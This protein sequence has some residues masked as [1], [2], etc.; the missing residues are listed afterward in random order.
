MEPITPAR[1]YLGVFVALLILTLATFAVSFVNLGPFNAVVAL[2]IAS[3]K[4]IL[5]VLF[6]MHARYST[7]ITRIVIVAGL[8]WLFILIAGTLD[9]YITRGWLG[10]P[11]K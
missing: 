11:G 1:T 10:V 7:G 9:D 3:S 6:F 5:I 4:A 2:A 8:V